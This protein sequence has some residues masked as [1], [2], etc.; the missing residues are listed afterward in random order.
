LSGSS[1]SS[2]VE[3]YALYALFTL[4]QFATD[5]PCGESIRQQAH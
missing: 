5:Q 2:A 3:I 4:H 1:V